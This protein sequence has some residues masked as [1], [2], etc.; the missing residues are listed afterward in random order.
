PA[1]I[2]E[3]AELT[4]SDGKLRNLLARVQS[5]ER[6]VRV[7][8]DEYALR[9]WGMEE[10]NGIADAMAKF[11]TANGGFATTDQLV[12]EIPEAFGV[13][14][15]SVRMYVYAPMF[16]VEGDTVRLRRDDEGYKVEDQLLSRKGVLRFGH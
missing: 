15:T 3:I 6:F 1:S 7:S 13:S 12:N 9:D 16:V 4:G 10:Y 5:D 11:I 2:G 8:K 14:P